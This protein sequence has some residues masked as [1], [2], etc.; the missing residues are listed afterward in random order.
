MVR[1]RDEGIRVLDVRAVA[2]AR[3]LDQRGVWKAIGERASETG[4]VA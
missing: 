4:G 1:S 2:E 3:Q